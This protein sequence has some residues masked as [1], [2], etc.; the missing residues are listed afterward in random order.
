M[1]LNIAGLARPVR[2]PPRS[3]LATL[4]AFSIFSSA[5]R[6]VSSIMCALSSGAGGGVDQRPDPLTPHRTGDVPLDE[7]VEHHDRHV[8][9]HAE[10]EGGGVGDL[11]ALLQHLAVGD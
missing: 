6:S 9:V 2:T 10:A 4:T 11:E 5:S 1:R 3:S 8:V 7:Q